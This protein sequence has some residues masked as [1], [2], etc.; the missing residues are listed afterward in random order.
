MTSKHSLR[1]V[2]L[3][4]LPLWIACGDPVADATLSVDLAIASVSPDQVSS[5]GGIEVTVKGRN[6]V[7]G[8]TARGV[9][10]GHRA[11]GEGR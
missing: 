6:F 2:L 3:A 7:P 9:P 5:G 8:M 4:L 11:G 10:R 1:V